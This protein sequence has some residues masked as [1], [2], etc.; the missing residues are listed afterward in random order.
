MNIV[1]GGMKMKVVGVNPKTGEEV[2]MEVDD[3]NNDFFK[4]MRDFVM[5]DEAIKSQIERLDISADAKE[6][7]YTF[8]KATIKVGEYVVKI[9]RK[10][11]DFICLVFKEYPTVTFGAIF[12]AIAG[13]LVSAIPLLG[14]ILGP[15]VTP[16]LIACGMVVGLYEDLKDKELAR[17]IAGINARFSPLGA[18]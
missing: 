11:I 2:E 7:L 12:G 14:L 9:G 13:F 10:I 6:L 3:L 18:R 5:S 1:K 8:S 15:I 17:K 4:S 16:I